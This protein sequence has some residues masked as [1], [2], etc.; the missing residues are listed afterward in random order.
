MSSRAL[1]QRRHARSGP[2]SAGSTGPR[3]TCRRLTAACRSRLVAAMIRTSTWIGA[4]AADP[5]ELA[6][7]QHAQQ[8][9]L[10]L[11][12]AASP[13]SSRKSV[14]P[15]ASSNW[16][17]RRCSAPVNAPF[18]WPNSSLSSSVSGMAAQLTATNGWSRRGPL[19]VDGARDQLLARAALAGDQHGRG[20]A[21]HLGDHPVDLLHLGVLARRARRSRGAARA[22]RAGIRPR[23]RASACRAPADQREQLVLVER[24]GDVVEGAQLHRLDRGADG[25]HR[26]HQDDL[27]PLVDRLDPLEDLDAVHPGQADVEQDQVHVGTAHDVESRPPRRATS[28][29]S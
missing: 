6:L 8:L 7:L 27:Q 20:R 14:P 9:D 16:P 29:T 21:G 26:G 24:L 18:S 25:L 12:P 23:A 28:M 17:S 4:C 15:W 22:R 3:G 19:V 13:I 11:G 2:R 5:L 1:A 10:Q